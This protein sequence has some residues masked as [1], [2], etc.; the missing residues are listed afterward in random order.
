MKRLIFWLGAL[1]VLNTMHAHAQEEPRDP[2]VT[3]LLTLFGEACVK[4]A[5][6]IDQVATWALL[7]ELP[8]KD[9]EQAAFFLRE[10]KGMVWTAPSDT[11][12]YALIAREPASCSVWAHRADPIEAATWFE[13]LLRKSMAKR[14]Q[15]NLMIDRNFDGAGGAYR[16]RAWRVRGEGAALLFTLTV[17]EAD[18]DDVPAQVIVSVSP[19]A[20]DGAKQ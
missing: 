1:A 17:T 14:D 3:E 15:L 19:V 9:A 2:R 13:K 20:D 11:G 5:G 18:S 8:E 12:R 10:Q 7:H 6:R 4:Q 16:L